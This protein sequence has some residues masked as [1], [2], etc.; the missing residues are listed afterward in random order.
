[1]NI[2]VWE[3][4]FSCQ[5]INILS[6]GDRFK[7]VH[8]TIGC[9]SL[10]VV[11]LLSLGSWCPQGDAVGGHILN[12]LLE[13]SRVVHQNHGERNFH[14]FYQLVE[15]GE[16][17]LLHQLGLERDAQH[18]NYLTQVCIT[19]WCCF[20]KIFMPPL[21][22]MRQFDNLMLFA[23]SDRESVPLCHPLMTETTGKQWKTLCKSSTL[24]RL[25][26]M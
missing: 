10:E 5:D 26:R 12:Y 17:D 8:W 3:W 16:D 21:I 14:I 11:E 2:N 9:F 23:V 22:F 19:R 4:N 15:G 6:N 20:S 13:K 25:T 24:R 1:M 18:Y 7:S